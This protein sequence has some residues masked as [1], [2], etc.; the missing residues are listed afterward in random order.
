MFWKVKY[1]DKNGK[2]DVL[3]FGG[4]ITEDEKR[5]RIQGLKDLGFRIVSCYQV[6]NI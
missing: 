5:R 2:E 3:Y 6:K 4:V 1:I